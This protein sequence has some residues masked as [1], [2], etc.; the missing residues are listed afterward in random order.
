MIGAGDAGKLTPLDAQM[1]GGV[2]AG[3]LKAAKV[4]T[5]AVIA[6]IAGKPALAPVELA[7]NLGY[8]A[9]LRDYSFSKYKTKKKDEAPEIASLAVITDET[10]AARKAFKPMEAVAEGVHL[11]RDLVNEPANELYPEEFAKRA[12][13]LTKL[14]LTV[15]VLDPRQLPSSAWVRFWAW[16]RA[17][18]IPPAWW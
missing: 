3:Q 11:A 6:E 4:K 7:V 10:T 1:L 16:R 15:E 18:P 2:A 12:R 9:R 5:A 14:G 13:A 17:R 8:G